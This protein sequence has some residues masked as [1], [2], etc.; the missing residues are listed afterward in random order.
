MLKGLGRN[1]I[2]RRFD[3]YYI[4]KLDISSGEFKYK[5]YWTLIFIIT[6]IIIIIKLAGVGDWPN[7]KEWVL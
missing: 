7:K 6:I 5:I 4:L 2:L 3:L 1:F